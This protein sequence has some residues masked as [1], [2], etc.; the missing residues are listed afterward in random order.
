MCAADWFDRRDSCNGCGY[1][2]NREEATTMKDEND[3][4]LAAGHG[5]GGGGIVVK[6]AF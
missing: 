1:G 6:I 5:R 4:G 3:A 2:R